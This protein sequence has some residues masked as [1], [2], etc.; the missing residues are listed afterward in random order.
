MKI[1]SI[2]QGSAM[3]HGTATADGKKFKWYYRP[4]SLFDMTEEE[5]SIPNCW[6]NIDPPAGAKEAVLKAVREARS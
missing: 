5:G 2:H 3:W 4:R 1:T 6:I